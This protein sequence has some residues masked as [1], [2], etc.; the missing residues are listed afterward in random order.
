LLIT[1]WES[2]LQN[3]QRLCLLFSVINLLQCTTFSF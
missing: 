3:E 1:Q 2:I